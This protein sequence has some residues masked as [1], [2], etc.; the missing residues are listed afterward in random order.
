MAKNVDD[1]LND[2][3]IQKILADMLRRIDAVIGDS[4]LTL[5]GD[6]PVFDIFGSSKFFEKMSINI[7]FCK[8]TE[9]HG[10]SQ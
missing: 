3:H 9:R 8:T 10:S 4:H 5:G 2:E 7:Y 6:I 1:F